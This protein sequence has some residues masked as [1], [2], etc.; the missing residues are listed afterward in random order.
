MVA[1]FASRLR[2]SQLATRYPQGESRQFRTRQERLTLLGVL[3]LLEITEEALALAQHILRT[4][5]IPVGFPEDAPHAAVAAV[6][7]IE[8]LPTWNYKPLA[9]AGMCGEI[10]AACRELGYEAMIICSPEELME[11]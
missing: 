6:N 3:T 1:S 8:Y 5:A 7:G 10:E 9:N 11:A 4:G 2:S